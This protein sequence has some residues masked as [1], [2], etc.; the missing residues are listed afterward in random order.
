MERRHLTSI[1]EKLA[2]IIIHLAD[3]NTAFR[4][5]VNKLHDKGKDNSQSHIEFEEKH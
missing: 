5:R 4:G 1:F 2:E 3:R